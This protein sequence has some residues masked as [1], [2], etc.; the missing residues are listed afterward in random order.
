[1][2]L[3]LLAARI[4]FERPS[5]R[6]QAAAL[7]FALLV[8]AV[9]SV[10]NAADVVRFNHA[11]YGFASMADVE[12]FR[13]AL[14]PGASVAATWDFTSF[15]YFAAPQA[16]YL[17]V[18][19]PLYQWVRFPKEHDELERTFAGVNV[20]VP[21]ALM[22]SLHSEYI[23]YHRELFPDLATRIDHDPR[24][25]RVFESG[26]HT[27][28]RVNASASPG[29]VTDWTIHWSEDPTFAEF[30]NRVDADEV[31]PAEYLIPA[32]AGLVKPR[33]SQRDGCWW[34]TRKALSSGSRRIRF[35]SAGPTSVY[36]DG[37]LRYQS[38][39]GHAGLI[40]AVSFETGPPRGA[41][42]QWAVRSC[43][44]PVYSSGFF[45]RISR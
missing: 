18:L 11:R 41:V 1:V 12:R 39:T 17:N 10:R 29:F 8:G 23:A 13:Q 43:P 5:Y 44:D 22:G 21:G 6:L 24:M 7:T 14:P 37:E 40:D 42:Q 32:A 26:G 15:Y 45:W 25:V 28:A 9:T 2:Y 38:A 31:T 3:T 33:V 27:I 35:G 4:R 19:D 30:A 34:A 36:V 16:T 20:D